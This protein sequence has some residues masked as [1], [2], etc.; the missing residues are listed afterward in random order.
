M[1]LAAV[2]GEE[3]AAKL[4]SIRFSG[5]SKPEISVSGSAAAGGGDEDTGDDIGRGR[6]WRWDGRGVECRG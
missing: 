4:I 6:G 2:D 3:V 1:L 5:P